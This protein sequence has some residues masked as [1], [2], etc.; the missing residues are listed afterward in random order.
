MRVERITS[1][2][3]VIR[4]IFCGTVHVLSNAMYS[5]SSGTQSQDTSSCKTTRAAC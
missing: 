1:Q 4:F 2:S 5:A 3:E